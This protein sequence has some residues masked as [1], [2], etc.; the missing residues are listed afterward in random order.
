MRQFI[1]I[2]LLLAVLSACTAVPPSGL[3]ASPT[4]PATAT[5]VPTETPL[6]ATPA[7]TA[8]ETTT[9][10]VE[11]SVG[12]N[13]QP[14]IVPTKPAKIPAPTQLDETTGLHMTGTVQE[15]DLASYRLKV[16]GMVDHPLKLSYDELRCLPKI[17]TS[18]VLACTGVFIDSATWSGVPISEVLKLAGVQPGAK[19]VQLV[20]ADGYQVTIDLEDALDRT[21]F[22]AY[23]MGGKPLP[24]LHGFPLRAVLPDM[25]G[26][27]WIKWL[28]E[29][30]VV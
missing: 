3:P 30:V 10:A 27:M 26:G 1:V 6:S 16:S 9:P 4:T 8:T 11:A 18:A 25:A 7:P 28:V 22:L 23:E 13:L 19:S 17:T 24:I 14:I 2:G 20:S 15:I 21:N 29:L 5:S 12:C